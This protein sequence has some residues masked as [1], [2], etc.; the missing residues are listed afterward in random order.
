MIG[1]IGSDT[2]KN[3]GLFDDLNNNPNYSV[4]YIEKPSYVKSIPLRAL[5][6]LRLDRFVRD[7]KLKP[8]Q[9]DLM[10]KINRYK[11]ILVIDTALRRL[12]LQFLEELRVKNPG[13]KIDCMLLNSVS[14]IAFNEY[15]I[16][17]KFQSFPWDTVLTFDPCDAQDN[18][19][20]YIGMNYY[21]KKP[22]PVSGLHESDLFFAGSIVGKRGERIIELLKYLNTNNV[23]CDFM[24]P[25]TDRKQRK[26]DFPE[27]MNL[28]CRRI[29]YSETL[30]R[31]EKSNCILEILQPGQGGGTLRYFEAVCYNKKLLTTNRMI[32]EYP[33][34][35]ERYM[36]IFSDFSEIDP[37]W[38]RKYEE[39]DYGYAGEFSP[40]KLNLED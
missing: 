34:Y 2:T 13:L 15:S 14:S 31:M 39:I 12:N 24:C 27:G 17:T 22:L 9:Y 21:S 6:K 1:I 32:T 11:K 29:S 3:Y 38:I 5:R 10:N 25:K 7:D 23:V 36:K 28:L 19:W 26:K 16:K 37:E 30:R 33:F 40:E 35:D 20:K 18:G 8:W 4:F